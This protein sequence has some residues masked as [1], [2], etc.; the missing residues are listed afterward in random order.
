MRKTKMLTVSVPEKLYND[1]EEI[2]KQTG[3]KRS[4]TV[5]KLIN[6]CLDNKA[7]FDAVFNPRIQNPKGGA[8]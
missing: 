3:Q 1:I 6:G 5:V 2:M 4:I 7:T 8:K